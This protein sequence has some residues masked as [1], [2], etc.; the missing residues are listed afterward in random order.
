[1]KRRISEG[2]E[3]EKEEGRMNGMKKG[4]MAVRKKLRDEK[5]EERRKDGGVQLALLLH[6]HINSEA[7][8]T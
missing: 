3:K 2:T 6:F 8:F 1:M 7:R 4:W 5:K